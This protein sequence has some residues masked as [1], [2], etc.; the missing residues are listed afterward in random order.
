MEDHHELEQ[1]L[2]AGL[3]SADRRHVKEQMRRNDADKLR[4]L[5]SRS[6]ADE[7]IADRDG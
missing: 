7:A 5:R 3:N 6:E 2:L 4:E 1:L